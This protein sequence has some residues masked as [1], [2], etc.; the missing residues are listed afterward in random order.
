MIG[1]MLL[2]D[3]SQAEV[4]SLRARAIGPWVGCCPVLE[5]CWTFKRDGYGPIQ[6]FRDD[7]GPLRSRREVV[8]II[9]KAIPSKEVVTI[10]QIT[11]KAH[12]Y[13]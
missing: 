5:V 2:C 3:S 8:R 6:I 12:A 9:H 7:D 13:S 11:V 4:T 1:K 10:I